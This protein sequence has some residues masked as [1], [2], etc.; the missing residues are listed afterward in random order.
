MSINNYTYHSRLG[1]E[2]GWGRNFFTNT[3]S[4]QLY[5]GEKLPLTQFEHAHQERKKKD[6]IWKKGNEAES[7]SNDTIKDN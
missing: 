6:K 3:F 7:K 5:M 4:S 1:S 2:Y